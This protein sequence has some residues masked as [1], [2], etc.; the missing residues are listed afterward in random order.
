MIIKEGNKRV[1]KGRDKLAEKIFNKIPYRYCFITG[2]FLYK[3]K[4]KDID[5]FVITRSKKKV[6]KIDKKINITFL[7][8]NDLYS[9]FYHSIS[10]YCLAKNNLPE[11]PIKITIASYW[12]VVSEA[13][14]LIFN[15]KNKFHKHIRDLVLYT[16]YLNKNKILDSIELKQKIAEFK[17][18]KEVLS[19][20]NKFLPLNIKNKAEKSYIK[21]FFYSQ[22]GFYKKNFDIAGQKYLYNEVHNIIK[23]VNSG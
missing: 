4:Y 15:E 14:P 3:D 21:R 13:I 1:I 9:L 19:Y 12:G 8:F 22:A 6:K 17:N 20:I 18:Y 23:V 10:K 16:E 2:S 7:D 5:M 11:R